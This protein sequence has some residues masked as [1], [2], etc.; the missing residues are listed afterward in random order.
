MNQFDVCQTIDRVVYSKVNKCVCTV[1]IYSKISRVCGQDHDFDEVMQE[2]ILT[3]DAIR[4]IEKV[5]K[6]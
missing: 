1:N 5:F 4:V 6:R 2:F 3:R